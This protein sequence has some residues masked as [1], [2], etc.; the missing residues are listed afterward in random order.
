MGSMTELMKK[1]QDPPDNP[2]R[3]AEPSAAPV[4]TEEAPSAFVPENSP[5]GP[6]ASFDEGGLTA[7]RELPPTGGPASV[8]MDNRTAKWDPKRVDPAVIAFHD[9]CASVC[10]QYRTVRARLL[11][12]NTAQA[13]QVIAVTSAVPQEGKSVSVLNLGMVMAEGGEHSILIADADFRRA[14]IAAMVGLDDGP[15]LVN[16][17]SGDAELADVL[18]PTPYPNLKIIPAGHYGHKN[19]AELLGGT[20]I[21]D[22]LDQFRDV[23]DYAFLDTPPITTVAD[24]GLLAPHCDGAIVVIQMERTPEPAVQQAVRTL[25]TNNVKILGSVLSRYRNHRSQY[26]GRYYNN[27]Y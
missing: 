6:E 25:Q 19:Y 7:V 12:S 20:V 21:H 2:D 9:R 11:T 27:Y 26:Y 15:G 5:P 18:R 17:L 10:E 14:S 16:V 3:T 8:E 4:A 24:V 13:S 22:V 23:F 1:L